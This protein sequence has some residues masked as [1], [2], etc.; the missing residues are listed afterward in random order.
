MTLCSFSLKKAYKKDREQLFAQEDN[1]KTSGNG[2][3]LKEGRFRQL[4]L[5]KDLFSTRDLSNA[6]TA[7]N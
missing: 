7:T 3:K 2:F 6:Y 4:L 5:L 1:D